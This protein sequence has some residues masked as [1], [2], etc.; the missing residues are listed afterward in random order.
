MCRIPHYVMCLLLVATCLANPANETLDYSFAGYEGGGVPLPDVAARIAVEPSPTG[1]DDTATIQAAINAVAK[2]PLDAEGFRG[3]VALRPGTFHVAGRI[4]MA[5]SGV[6]LRG[7]DSTLVATGQS[8]R[9]L[10]EIGGENRHPLLPTVSITDGYVPAGAR[11]FSVESTTPFTVG[12]R[13]LVHRPSTQAWISAL[14]MDRFKG[15]AGPPHTFDKLRLPWLAGSRDL[16]WV[17]TIVQIDPVARHLVLDAPITTAL[18]VNFGGGTVTQIC[19]GNRVSHIGVE[20]LTCVSEYDPTHP[21]DEEHA[22]IAISADH[23]DDAWMRRVVVRHFVCAAVWLAPDACRITAEDCASEQPVSEFAG[24]R[25]V[26][27]FVEG[28]QVLLLRCTADDGR[29]DFV[30]GHGAPGPDVFLDCTS[31]HAHGNSGAF[32]SWA[33]GFLY[34]GTRIDGGGLVLGNIGTAMQAAGWAM[35][36]STAW[37]CTATAGVRTEN[38]PGAVN[39]ATTDVSI[40]SLYRAQLAARLGEHAISA[41]APSSRHSDPTQIPTIPHT[42]ASPPLVV[43]QQLSIVHGWFTAGGRVLVGGTME[44][45][46]WRGQ[47][48][49]IPSNPDPD[50][51]TGLE[52]SPTRWAPGRTGPGHTEDLDELCAAQLAQQTPFFMASPGLWYDR[53]RDEHSTWARDTADVWGPFFE[54]PWARS[55]EGR[56]FDGLSRY[57]LTKYNPWYWGRLRQFAEASARAGTVL[58]HHFYQNHNVMEAAAHWTDFPWCE[59]NCLQQTGLPDPAP[60]NGQM[61]YLPD[62][63]KRFYEVR[64]PVR[65]DLHRRLIL[66]GLDVLGTETNVIHTV[67][68]EF[69]GPLEFQRLFLDTVAEWERAHQRHVHIALYTSKAVTDA[70]LED[71]TRSA[72]VDVIHLGN[73]QY[74]RDGRLFA[75]DGKGEKAFRTLRTEYFGTYDGPVPPGTPELVYRQVREYRDRYPDKAIMCD[76]A[77]QGPIPIVMAGGGAPIIDADKKDPHDARNDAAFFRFIDAHLSTTLPRMTPSDEVASDGTWCLCDKHEAYLLYSL[78][79]PAIHLARQLNVPHAVGVWFDPRSGQTRPAALGDTLSIA[80]PSEAPWLLFVHGKAA[81]E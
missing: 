4:R 23:V 67:G 75:P 78:R 38:P 16:E 13:V 26:S 72:L 55:G 53:R 33:S 32:E 76:D 27:F 71:P 14:G 63:G 19:P 62:V 64:N 52:R 49:P 2:L 10:I 47:L 50:P 6:V 68:A 35:A 60:V 74:L 36:N 81:T 69:A 70:I 45:A 9:T 46:L 42:P 37:N 22:W 30:G 54:M 56:A 77:G 21:F 15:P 44:S 17:R 24:W 80:K 66:H 28:Q 20:N 25:R 31:T 8:R 43:Q 34:D 12:M 73:W 7:N 65:R 41:L 58:V 11:E 29:N 3:A 5:V 39:R 61:T 51:D 40:R 57:D 48:P 18:D 1:A 59:V 79:G